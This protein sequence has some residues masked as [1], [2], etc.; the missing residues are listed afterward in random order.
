MATWGRTFQPRYTKP[1]KESPAVLSPPLPLGDLIQRLA[2]EDLEGRAKE[3]N[4]LATI[5]NARTITSYNWADKPRSDP[6][7]LTPGR[8]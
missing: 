1:P 2:A 4:G 7:I 8:R 3:F 6:T 5:D